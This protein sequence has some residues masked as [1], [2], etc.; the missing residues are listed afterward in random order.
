MLLTDI[1][2]LFVGFYELKIAEFNLFKRCTASTVKKCP[3]LESN[4]GH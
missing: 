2:H 3:L 1:K 4:E